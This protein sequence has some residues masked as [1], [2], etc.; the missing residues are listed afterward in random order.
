[1]NATL[2]PLPSQPALRSQ[3]TADGGG[4]GR[5]G[6]Q[7]VGLGCEPGTAPAPA[8]PAGRACPTWVNGYV[9]EPIAMTDAV[10]LNEVLQPALAIVRAHPRP[11]DFREDTG[12]WAGWSAGSKKTNPEGRITLKA[13]LLDGSP[14]RLIGIYLHELAHCLVD[15]AEEAIEGRETFLH[16]HDAA[17]LAVQL[18]MFLRLDQSGFKS[19]NASTWFNAAKFYDLQDPPP[20]WLDSPNVTWMP[21]ALAWALEQAT[22]LAAADLDALE[23]TSEICLRYW[24]WCDSMAA[25][26][27]Q[28]AAAAE[29]ARVA[30]AQQQQ[31]VQSL[32]TDLQL[33]RWLTMLSSGALLSGAWAW[34]AR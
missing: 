31:L 20:C 13:A 15:Q 22:E 2:S 17:F 16:S 27:S 4:T 9:V 6:T 24:T 5:L 32:R 19:D 28:L 1:M 26:P 23:V 18:A 11:V 3:A 12:L 30:K 21:R 14:S 34:L 10:R 33:F 25:E 29:R 8:R 7:P